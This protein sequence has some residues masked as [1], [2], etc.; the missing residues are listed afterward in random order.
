MKKKR[1]RNKK[2]N[3]RKKKRKEKINWYFLL[4]NILWFRVD[5]SLEYK[6]ERLC[7]E[8][9]FLVIYSVEVL[10]KKKKKKFFFFFFF[11]GVRFTHYIFSSSKLIIQDEVWVFSFLISLFLLWISLWIMAII[12]ISYFFFSEHLP[13]WYWHIVAEGKGGGISKQILKQIKQNKYDRNTSLLSQKM[14][15]L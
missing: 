4:I 10:K 7:L 11:P 5:K 13:L 1:K 8:V 9:H 15:M 6:N 2:E 3:S 14:V 12:F